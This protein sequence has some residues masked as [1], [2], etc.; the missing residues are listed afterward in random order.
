MIEPH[1][2]SDIELLLKSNDEQ[3]ILDAIMHM[4]FN[5]NDPEWIQKKC[6]EQINLKKSSNITGLAITCL[7]HIARLHGVINENTTI[8]LLKKLLKDKEFS[9]RAEDALDDIEQ[10]TKK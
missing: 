2:K 3:T 1:Q 10:F 4:T 7:G 8:P 6:I 9:G 5:V